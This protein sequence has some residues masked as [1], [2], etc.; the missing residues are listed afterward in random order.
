MGKIGDTLKLYMGKILVACFGQ[1]P[2][3]GQAFT[4]LLSYIVLGSI[5]FSIIPSVCFHLLEGW[6]V[7]GFA[8]SMNIVFWIRY[9]QIVT[10][11]IVT[12]CDFWEKFRKLSKN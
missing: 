3:K 1:H 4:I 11:Q 5:I 7:R 8:T 6:L 9:H 12:L 10:Q 2:T